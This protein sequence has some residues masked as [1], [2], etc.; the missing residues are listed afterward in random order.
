[1]SNVKQV[2]K[3][4]I[5]TLKL[6]DQESLALNDAMVKIGNEIKSSI[7]ALFDSA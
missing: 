6:K 7:E 3:V 1:L 5:Q 2:K 4:T